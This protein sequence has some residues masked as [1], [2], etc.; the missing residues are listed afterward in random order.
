M[1]LY[2]RSFLSSSNHLRTARFLSRRTN[3]QR[4]QM[5]KPAQFL[6]FVHALTATVPFLLL[7]GQYA[8]TQYITSVQ[9]SGSSGN[10]TIAIT[11]AGFGKLTETLP[12]TG[13]TSNFAVTDR[14]TNTKYGHSGNSDY[15]TYKVWTDTAI[16]VSG[17]GGNPGDVTDIDVWNLVTYTGATWGGKVPGGSSTPKISSVSFRGSDQDLEITV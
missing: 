4:G 13:D 5:M 12:F 15:L 3:C 2:L 9:F 10:Y 7:S 17:Y 8:H 16:T 6:R 1:V 14:S 11:G